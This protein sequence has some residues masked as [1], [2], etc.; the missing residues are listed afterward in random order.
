VN[1]TIVIIG[2]VQALFGILIFSTKR[3]KHLSFTFLIIWLATIAIFLGAGL[4][5]FEVV[6]YFKPGIFPFL[7]LFGPLFY[8][9]VSSLV[10]EHFKLKLIMLLHLLPFLA[11]SIHRSTINAVSITSPSSL[12]ENPSYIY[13]KIY[14]SLLILSS[15]IYW[16]FCL[17]LVLKH[18]KNLPFHFSNYTTKNSLTWLIFILTMFM[19]LLITNFLM[20]FLDNILEIKTIKMFSLGLNLTIFSFVIIFFGNNQSVLYDNRKMLMLKSKNPDNQENDEEKYSRISLDEK[21][22]EALSETVFQY[23]KSEKPYLNP[24]YSLQMMAD[25]LN[26]SRHKLSQIINSSQKKNFYKFINEF[27]VEEVK[28]KLVDPAFNNYNLL[29]IALECGFNSKTSFN[30]IFKEITGLTPSEFKNSI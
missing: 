11:V 20:F 26:I 10:I 5:P 8:L 23:L 3:P 17:Q 4:L 27:R 28:E 9:Y 12:S 25:D 1:R 21:Q 24:E 7:F 6:D 14:Y 2:F 19:F 22:K 18:R 15:F 16:F 29:G 30:R 13:I